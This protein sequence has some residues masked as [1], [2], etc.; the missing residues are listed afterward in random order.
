MNRKKALSDLIEAKSWEKALCLMEDVVRQEDGSIDSYLNYIFLL[1]TIALY[2]D[3]GSAIRGEAQRMMPKAYAAAK[4]KYADTPDFL[5]FFG[6]IASRCGWFYD[7]DPEFPKRIFRRAHEMCPDNELYRM[8][9]LDRGP[10]EEN[11]PFHWW[12]VRNMENYGMM[13]KL[14]NLGPIGLDFISCLVGVLTTQAMIHGKKSLEE[15][16]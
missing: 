12:I 1:E 4:E 10:C 14:I 6:F 7:E 11:E 16:N 5:F 13:S 2:A 3:F 15:K 9:E 8:S